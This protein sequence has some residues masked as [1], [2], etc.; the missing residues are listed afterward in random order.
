MGT[1]SAIE[2]T[3]HTFNPWMGCQKVSRA[4]Q[5]CYAEAWADRYYQ[6][7]GLWRGERRRTSSSTWRNPRRWNRQAIEDGT[8]ALVFCA[9]L[10]DVFEGLDVLTE[11]RAEL[12]E[13]IRATP[14]LRWLLLTKR[15]ENVADMLPDDWGPTG[16]DNVAIGC[17]VEDQDTAN[18][19]IHHLL[20]VPARWRFLSLEPLVGPVDLR[21]LPSHMETGDPPRAAHRPLLRLDS[22]TGRHLVQDPDGPVHGYNLDAG[23]PE[24]DDGSPQR[25][26]H[27]VIAGGESGPHAE[28]SDPAW[29]QRLRDDC[30]HAGV[31]FLFKQWGAWVP[32]PP[33]FTPRAGVT[34]PKMTTTSEGT[35]M[36]RLG[37]KAAGRRL[38]GQHHNGMPDWGTLTREDEHAEQ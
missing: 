30:Y 10:A 1:R 12:F 9:S 20:R 21:R 8:P 33:C 22:L 26:L 37:K 25:R 32:V 3:D 28:P 27:W 14:A 17:T 2:W 23:D 16:W 15:P 5:H 35:Q 6:G 19:R 31:P 36:A 13:L 18:E 38:D 11:W 34:P 24:E 7:E 4:C 29:F